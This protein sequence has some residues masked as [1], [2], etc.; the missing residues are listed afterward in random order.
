MSFNATDLSHLHQI[1]FSS[2]WD[3]GVMIRAGDRDRLACLGFHVCSSIIGSADV[4]RQRAD[5][6]TPGI[7]PLM[8]EVL[9]SEG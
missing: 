2:L 8:P 4:K 5:A 9:A 3:S 7:S 6:S 1:F